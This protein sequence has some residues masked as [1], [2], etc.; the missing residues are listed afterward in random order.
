M[1]IA[2]DSHGWKPDIQMKMHEQEGNRL[3]KAKVPFD[4]NAR[5]F[6]KYVINNSEW[7]C[8]ASKS[9]DKGNMNNYI[10]I[11]VVKTEEDYKR[12]EEQYEHITHYNY[13]SK[14]I[15]NTVN[16]NDDTV[17]ATVNAHVMRKA[18]LPLCENKYS[19]SSD[20]KYLRRTLNRIRNLIDIILNLNEFKPTPS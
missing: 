7:K 3:F 16:A 9:D 8:D 1:C 5:H 19:N 13:S 17:K 4:N 12:M 15:Y 6:Y 20:L 11:G 14:D 2:L 18:A 10:D